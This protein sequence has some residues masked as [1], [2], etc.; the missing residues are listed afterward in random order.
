MD[1]VRAPDQVTHHC[2][3]LQSVG[4]Q[5]LQAEFRASGAVFLAFAAYVERHGRGNGLVPVNLL[6]NIAADGH[7][8]AATGKAARHASSVSTA[9]GWP[10]SRNFMAESIFWP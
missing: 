6:A 7:A 8:V 3:A 9:M 10:F 4:G 2:R 5:S 1:S